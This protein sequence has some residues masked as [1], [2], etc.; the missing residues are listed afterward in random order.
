MFV[1]AATTTGPASAAGGRVTINSGEH[2]VLQSFALFRTRD[3]KSF[4]VT[5]KIIKRPDKG[6]VWVTEGTLD[7]AEGFGGGFHSS[8]CNGVNLRAKWLHYRAPKGFRGKVHIIV[9][10]P[11]IQ[12]GRNQHYHVTVK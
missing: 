5:L 4:N 7:P 10:A 3:C 8:R 2:I 12:D 6:K 9:R 1:A 11:G